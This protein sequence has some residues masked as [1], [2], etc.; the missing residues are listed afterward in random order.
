MYTLKEIY[1]F[2]SD[3]DKDTLKS[4]FDKCYD[5]L[6]EINK[7]S[8][9][10]TVFVLI[11]LAIYFFPSFI[12]EGNISGFKIS[13]NIIKVLS[14]LL[15]PYFILEWCLIAKRRR[16]LVKVMKC[17]GYKIFRTP[18]TNEEVNPFF[19]NIHTRNAIPFSFMVE[20][21]NIN[22]KSKAYVLFNA[23]FIV[24][25]M[26]GMAAYLS[27]LAYSSFKRPDL[28]IAAV[29]CNLLGLFCLLQIFLFYIGDF[30]N[31]TRILR[32]DAR[33]ISSGE[34]AKFDLRIDPDN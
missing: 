11:L 21:L 20:L 9:L 6:K 23:L 19:L 13:L 24:C 15:V 33:F 16:E 1:Q 25:M 12:T 2:V 14:P 30:K 4:Y 27:Y 18:N 17:V 26:L 28:N 32:E 34:S 3:R 29:G 5:T 8:S 22:T 7:R 10:L 31:V